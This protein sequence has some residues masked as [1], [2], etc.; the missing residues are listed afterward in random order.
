LK[1]KDLDREIALRLNNTDFLKVGFLNR[2]M[3]KI[4]EEDRYLLYKK[5]LQKYYP[6]SIKIKDVYKENWKEYYVSVVKTIC[7]LKH[8]DFDYKFG[9][10]FKQLMILQN[11]G[12]AK[13]KS[14]ILYYGIVHNELALVKYAIETGNIIRKYHVLD[15]ASLD[16]PSILKYL[17]EKGAPTYFF[18]QYYWERISP[19]CREFLKDLL[20][21]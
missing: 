19:S 3:Y 1:V 8:Y 4:Y 20:K 6:D 16:D 17:L 21:F 10:P 12:N 5:R 14:S 15:A 2:Y 18:N 11:I 13:L 7:R 9:N